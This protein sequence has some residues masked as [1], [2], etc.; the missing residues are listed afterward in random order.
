M[1]DLVGTTL[2]DQY[3]LRRLVDS[4]GT[5]NVYQA[6]DRVRS[7]NMAVKILRHD[8]SSDS[9]LIIMFEE[10]AALLRQLQHPNIVRLYEFDKQDNIVY[11]IMDWVDG[12]NLRQ[13]ITKNQKPFTFDETLH[14][15]EPI[16]IALNYAH[17]KKIFH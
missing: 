6:W 9:R 3:F 11:F 12:S 5:A 17:Q 1:T 10:E 16:S 15:L 2:K 4:G 7:T 8:L 14:I 13:A